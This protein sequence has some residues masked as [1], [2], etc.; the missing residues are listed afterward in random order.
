MAAATNSRAGNCVSRNLHPAQDPAAAPLGTD[1]E[2]AGTPI[3]PARAERV[4][5]AEVRPDGE[6][7][8]RQNATPSAA[9]TTASGN[10]TGRLRATML[11]LGIGGAIGV[12]AAL[13][14]GAMGR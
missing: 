9:E 8:S 4:R 5:L 13:I 2:A 6:A 12:A 1:E 7:L 14:A 11:W 3:D 10:G